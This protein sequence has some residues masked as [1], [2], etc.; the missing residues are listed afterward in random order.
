MSDKINLKVKKNQ[1]KKIVNFSSSSSIFFG[2]ALVSAIGIILIN[3]FLR[4]QLNNLINQENQV[5]AQYNALGAKRA[6]YLVT[7]QQLQSIHTVLS[8]R[9]ALGE[10]LNG[11]L[12]I[13][14][15]QL[16]FSSI[17]AD[18]SKIE[19]GISSSDLS[20]LNTILSQSL[21]SYAKEARSNVQSI[22]LTSFGTG[23]NETEAGQYDVAFQINYR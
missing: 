23:N 5:I 13:L 8:T 14:P 1:S 9:Q 10:R 21:Q 11:L 20:A 19:I 17:T 12:T 6:K 3:L 15:P 18:N 22:N 4:T 2:I 16:T 7:Q